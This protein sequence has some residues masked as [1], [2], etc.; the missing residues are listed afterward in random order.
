MIKIEN[1]SRKKILTRFWTYKLLQQ[2]LLRN[3]FLT[4]QILQYKDQQVIYML[5]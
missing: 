2:I 4:D 3:E 5:S 1:L